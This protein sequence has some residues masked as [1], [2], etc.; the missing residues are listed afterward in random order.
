MDEKVTPV[1]VVVHGA[2][3]LLALPG[4]RG[5]AFVQ[6]PRSAESTVPSLHPP[7][8][9]GADLP[10]P[11]PKSVVRYDAATVGQQI[12]DILE[13]QAVSVLHP[14]GVADAGRR[15]ALPKVAG[16]SK[17]QPGLEPRAA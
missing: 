11:L 7:D 16:S 1:T 6:T 5:A 8:V 2:P 9:L 14:D 15:N 3:Q 12:L 10:A 4:D 17:V 13:A